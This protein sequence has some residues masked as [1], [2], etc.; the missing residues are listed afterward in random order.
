MS[1]SFL[2]KG[3]AAHEAVAQADAETEARKK[4]AGIRRYWIPQDGEGQVTFLDGDLTKDGLLDAVAYYEHQ[5][6]LNGHFRNW[7]PCTADSEPCPICDG[8]DNPS[9]V[10]AFTVIDHN[11]WK[12]KN[13]VVH[14]HE[15]RLFVCKRDTFK[16]LQKIA[17][18]REGLAGATFDVARSG[19]KSSNVGNMFDFTEKQSPEAIAKKYG[20][21]LDDV[22]PYDYGEVIQYFPAAELKKLGFGLVGGIGSEDVATQTAPAEE[23]DYDQSL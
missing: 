2:K 1:V 12:D 22:Q 13:G 23:P 11:K 21:E 5:V 3:Q 4:S 19:E 10:T 15:R 7:F 14:Q 8:G 6:K 9:L 18:K 17:T 16:M 20:L